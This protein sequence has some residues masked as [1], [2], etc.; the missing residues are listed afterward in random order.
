M[1]G[2]EAEGIRAAI[3]E[4]IDAQDAGDAGRLRSLP[5]EW[6]DAVHIG[7]DVGEWWT[8]GELLD[9][10]AVGGD[11]DIQMIADDVRIKGDVAWTEGRGRVTSQSG[12]ARPVRMTSVLIREHGRWTMAQSHA[13]IA[14]PNADIFS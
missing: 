1:A 7:T 13:S 9:A 5:S 2:T 8:S 4:M 3:G 6:P 14:V 11:G 12:C 10:V